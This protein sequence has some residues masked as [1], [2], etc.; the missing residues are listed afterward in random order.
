MKTR[1]LIVCKTFGWLWMGVLEIS[2]AVWFRNPFSWDMALRQ[3]VSSY[4]PFEGLYF[5]NI[6]GPSS[7][8]FVWQSSRTSAPSKMTE[9]QSIETS[10]TV[11]QWRGVILQ[12]D[13]SITLGLGSQH[14]RLSKMFPLG[15]H[16]PEWLS[17]SIMPRM[18]RKVKISLSEPWLHTGGVVV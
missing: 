11:I 5:L 6:Q 10:V 13:S 9:L 4:R 3:G 2:A 8:T 16:P 7:L 15:F 12:K 1:R 14:Y 18:W 17:C